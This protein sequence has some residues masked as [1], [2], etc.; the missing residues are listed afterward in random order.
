MLNLYLTTNKKKFFFFHV[1]VKFV[2]RAMHYLITFAGK[3][4]P[5]F[6]FFFFFLLL[7]LLNCFVQTVCQSSREKFI[8]AKHEIYSL[9]DKIN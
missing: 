6:I 1:T 8:D 2:Y 3:Y 4:M 5:V 7:S 9:G